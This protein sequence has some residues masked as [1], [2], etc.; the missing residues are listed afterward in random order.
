M[1]GDGMEFTIREMGASDRAIWRR[2]GLPFG[3]MR[4]VKHT[5]TGIDAVLASDDMWGFVAE[6]RDGAPVGFA[7]V[8]VRKY[9]N[10]C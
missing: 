2:C 6:S 9:A 1:S 3:P 10:G 8:A 5:A 4:R 7:E